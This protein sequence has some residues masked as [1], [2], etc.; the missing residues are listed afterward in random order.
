MNEYEVVLSMLQVINEDKRFSKFT[1]KE[2]FINMWHDFLNGVDGSIRYFVKDLD[3]EDQLYRF[4]FPVSNNS[5]NFEF[6]IKYI[7]D[8]FSKHP[9]C[10][11]PIIFDNVDGKLFQN[12]FGCYYTHIADSDL[13]DV[14]ND[15]D[16]HNAYIIPFIQNQYAFLAI[17]GNHRICYQIKKNIK[18]IK[19]LYFH[20]VIA[21]RALGTPFQVCAFCLN[22]D[23]QRIIYNVG[24]VQDDR[25]LMATNIVQKNKILDIINERQKKS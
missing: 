2:K 17:D 3:N 21:A 4:E 16:L 25:L 5:M 8:I 12:N 19:A 23:F 6:S 10:A 14:K 18:Q 15:T 22:N 1:H 13:E 9:E 7:R 20:D 11:N 24:H